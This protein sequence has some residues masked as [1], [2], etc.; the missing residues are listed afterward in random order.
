MAASLAWQP[1]HAYATSCPFGTIGN[2]RSLEVLNEWCAHDDNCNEEC[3][4]V[5]NQ[6]CYHVLYQCNEPNFNNYYVLECQGWCSPQS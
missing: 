4:M 2:C 5:S 6:C 1:R 3:C